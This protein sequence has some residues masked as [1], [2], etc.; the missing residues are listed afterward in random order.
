MKK[1]TFGIIFVMFFTSQSWWFDEF[2]YL[3]K[4][5]TNAK[6]SSKWILIQIKF[7]RVFNRNKQHSDFQSN[8]LFIKFRRWFYGRVNFFSD[9]GRHKKYKFNFWT[10]VCSNFKTQWC[11]LK[12]LTQFLK[13]KMV[14]NDRIVKRRKYFNSNIR[15]WF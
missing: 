5:I 14:F 3:D 2:R 9:F 8:I 7:I 11:S 12:L 10:S 6:F 4:I 13:N 15:A 1:K